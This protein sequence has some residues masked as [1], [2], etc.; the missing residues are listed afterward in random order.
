MIEVTVKNKGKVPRSRAGV[1]WPGRATH[2]AKVSPARVRE[3]KACRS[4]TLVSQATAG[5]PAKSAPAA[6]AA[7]GK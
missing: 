6:K 2:K 1:V 5:K 4:L 3:I 7:E